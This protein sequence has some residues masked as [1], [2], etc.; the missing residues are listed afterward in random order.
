MTH[1]ER[2]LAILTN[3]NI[4]DARVRVPYS[5]YLVALKLTTLGY[6]VQLR[7]EREVTSADVYLSDIRKRIEVKSGKYED[8][9]CGRYTAASFGSGNQLV[10]DKFDYCAFVTFE[11]NT[12]K[13]I[14]LFSKKQLSEV[15]NKRPKL[16][17]HETNQCLL[18]LYKNYKDYLK[19]L[20]DY[21]KSYKLQIEDEFNRQPDKYREK[22]NS[23]NK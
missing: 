6:Q 16:A 20:R 10:K 17:G 21:P 7:E 4:E 23:I 14:F 5:E 8:D 13:E 3:R 12:A 19:M 11:Q 9:K 15:K 2:I 1:F 22:W 18:I